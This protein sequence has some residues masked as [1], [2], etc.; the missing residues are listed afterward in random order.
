MTS[1]RTCGRRYYDEI[2][3]RYNRCKRK[4]PTDQWCCDYCMEYR[5]RK[6]RRVQSI[7]PSNLNGK[8][9]CYEEGDMLKCKDVPKD[10]LFLDLTL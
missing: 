5:V 6:D 8:Q 1:I 2:L 4:R 10:Y 7:Y 3:E 9:I